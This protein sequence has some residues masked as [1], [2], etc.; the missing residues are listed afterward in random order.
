MT[1]CHFDIGLK[2]LVDQYGNTEN[3][4]V[5]ALYA[6]NALLNSKKI[7]ESEEFFEKA[8][9][10]SSIEVVVGA[11]AGLGIC[12]ETKEDWTTAGDFY[13]KAS[14]TTTQKG[15]KDKFKLYAALNFEKGKNIDR[16]IKIFREIIQGESTEY[17]LE[18][19][20]G[21]TRLGMIVE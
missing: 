4:K 17:I 2:E 14:Q 10:S 13:E 3:G 5:A 11:Y 7:L 19:K 18:A 6:G 16:S 21:L 1:T 12:K 9:S 15:L 20:S 8:I